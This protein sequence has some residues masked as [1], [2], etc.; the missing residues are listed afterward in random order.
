MPLTQVLLQSFNHALSRLLLDLERLGDGRWDKG[1]VAD[2]GERNEAHTIGEPVP[3]LPCYLEAQP[4]LAYPAGARECK[5]TYVGLQQL[6]P[7]LLR[8]SLPAD[9]SS[10]RR[11]KAG[12]LSDT[13]G[14]AAGGLAC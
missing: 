2:G 6:L 10:E 14:S 3:N 5:E 11:G 1:W 13:S 9:K 8:F 7:H 12:G 4:S